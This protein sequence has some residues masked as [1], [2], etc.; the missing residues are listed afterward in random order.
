MV[1]KHHQRVNKYFGEHGIFIHFAHQLACCMKHH[2]RAVRSTSDDP[3]TTTEFSR[4]VLDYHTDLMLSLFDYLGNG[5]DERCTGAYLISLLAGPYGLGATRLATTDEDDYTVSVCQTRA[6]LAKLQEALRQ[7][8]PAFVAIGDF[9]DFLRPNTGADAIPTDGEIENL[10]PLT[11]LS[12]I[13]LGTEHQGGRYASP[14]EAYIVYC[15]VVASCT[16]MNVKLPTGVLD[17]INDRLKTICGS[18]KDF[19]G[20]SV[21][22]SGDFFQLP[23]VGGSPMFVVSPLANDANKNL[24]QLYSRIN[25]SVFLTEP[26]RQTDAAFDA[27]LTKIR[28]GDSDEATSDYFSGR[29]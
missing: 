11:P 26:M 23:P 20:K 10:L 25:K 21:I 28:N 5:L 24:E 8:M 17:S 14:T 4:K 19:G 18:D 13:D 27:E 9:N 22:F 15:K 3:V 7:Y 12:S 29:Y 16:E 1:S 6:M 2:Q